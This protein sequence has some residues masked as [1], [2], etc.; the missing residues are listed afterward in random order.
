VAPDPGIAGNRTPVRRRWW[1]LAGL[2]LLVLGGACP[3]AA[4]DRRLAAVRFDLGGFDPNRGPLAIG[5]RLLADA[6]A[7]T[8]RVSDF[9]GKTIAR[10]SMGDVREGTRRILWDGRRN[11]QVLPEGRYRLSLEAAF[12]DGPVA[13]EPM[14][15]RVIRAPALAT[16][17]PPLP[18][19]A[20]PAWA[21]TGRLSAFHR[22]NPDLPA[23]GSTESEQWGVL[24]LRYRDPRRS[25]EGVLAL[26]RRS[27]GSTSDNGSQGRFR[28]QW[29]AVRLKGVFRSDLG[30]FDDPLTLFADYRTARKK[31]GVRAEI[32]TARM[33]VTALAF[34]SEG[35]VDSGESGAG[36][37]LRVG[38]PD[39]FQLGASYTGRR[40]QPA[41]GTGGR[42]HTD[43]TGALDLRLPL[44]GSFG[45]LAEAAGSNPAL[46]ESDTAWLALAT[47]RSAAVRATAGYV[48][49]GEQFTA[50][51]ADPLR[52]VA[53]NARGWQASVDIRR[54]RPWGAVADLS[55]AGRGF[56]MARPSSGAP[57]DEIDLLLRCRLGTS[58]TVLLNV[59]G[60]RDGPARSASTRASWRHSWS[61][62][63]SS[64][65]Q[66]NYS[67][68][69]S[70]GTW[71]GVLGTGWQR[72][73]TNLGVALE[74]IRR[75]VGG[76]GAVFEEL[77]VLLDARRGRWVLNAA[78]RHHR[79]P[80]FQ[81]TNLYGRLAYARRFLHR[82]TL[83]GY[84][85]L[86]RQAALR[87]EGQVEAGLEVGF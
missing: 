8:L 70:G 86:G 12:P 1:A 5:F 84:L 26:R 23:G 40:W 60:R 13:S 79:R 43:H 57:L 4:D 28:Q 37:R 17:L 63:W 52:Q 44:T 49:L 29:R 41:D 56:V 46:G 27:D 20:P 76:S 6:D 11:G 18:E 9:R 15:A 47:Y 73:E 10:L 55:F 38:S 78:A 24:G 58:E 85:A 53:A 30:T 80:D 32:N 59:L 87:S 82:Y 72:G 68:S 7:V 69:T 19:P 48:D 65:L 77:A 45:C 51:F 61:P 31:G 34:G 50:G 75:E 71:R 2:L 74:A 14:E 81:G 3:A 22:T 16:D 36:A 39:R 42:R 66:G 54:H 83:G 21:V 62:A 33:S 25:G 64:T 67:E 35:D